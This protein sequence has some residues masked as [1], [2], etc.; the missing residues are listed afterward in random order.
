M[1]VKPRGSSSSYFTNVC[2]VAP[3][4]TSTNVHVK[5]LDGSSH[6]QR[7]L[8]VLAGCHLK[9]VYHVV[10]VVIKLGLLQE[11]RIFVGGLAEKRLRR[12]ALRGSGWPLDSAPCLHWLSEEGGKPCGC[13]FLLRLCRSHGPRKSR[14]WRCHRHAFSLTFTFSPEGHHGK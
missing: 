14:R 9:G 13:S 12:S 7:L 11:G 8:L 2:F 6:S 1:L 10:V 5:P 4:R 3:S